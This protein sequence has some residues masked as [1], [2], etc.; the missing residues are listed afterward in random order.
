MPVSRTKGTV[1]ASKGFAIYRIIFGSV[2]LGLGVSQ[3]LEYPNHSLPYFTLAIGALFFV[4]GVVAL[5]AG[6]AIGSRVEMD[7]V[8]PSAAERLDELERLKT[9]GL[10]SEQEYATKRQD[11]L[12][13]L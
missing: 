8:A 7:T 2:F 4:Y 3:Y 1:R 6:K 5:V 13:D 10:I 11:I 12:K 9:S